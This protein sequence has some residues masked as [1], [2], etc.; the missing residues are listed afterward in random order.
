MIDKCNA[1]R[2]DKATLVTGIC[3]WRAEGED[4]AEMTITGGELL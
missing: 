3:E 4:R 1:V 2:T